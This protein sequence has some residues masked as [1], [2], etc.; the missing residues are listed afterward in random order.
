MRDSYETKK[1]FSKR[2][3]NYL[4]ID[5]KIQTINIYCDLLEEWGIFEVN[6]V[7]SFLSMLEDANNIDNFSTPPTF[8][9]NEEVLKAQKVGADY[10]TYSPIFTT[11]NKGKPKGIEDL[12]IILDKVDIKVFALG[13]IINKA[14]IE[15]IASTKAFGFASI[16]YFY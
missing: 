5:E 8:E 1:L 10:V 15:E 7:R 13:G 16:R 6:I 2:I 4:S 3:N 12:K 9:V 11:P 14:Q